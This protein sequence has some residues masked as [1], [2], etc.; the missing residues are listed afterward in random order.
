MGGVLYLKT[1]RVAPLWTF[2]ASTVAVDM[3][4]ISHMVQSFCS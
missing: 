1:K 2:L 3:L 4:F